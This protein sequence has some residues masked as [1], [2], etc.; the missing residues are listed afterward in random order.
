M[1]SESTCVEP[2]PGMTL[3]VFNSSRS[4]PSTTTTFLP[5]SSLLSVAMPRP[6]CCSPRTRTY[7]YTYRS[8]ESIELFPLTVPGPFC[9]PACRFEDIDSS[10]CETTA[11]TILLNGRQ[12]GRRSPK[13]VCRY[14][15]CHSTNH[16]SSRSS[17]ITTMAGTDGNR[18]SPK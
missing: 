5:F 15:Y 9:L 3:I 12:P 2:N 16:R 14:L 10:S 7:A 6:H 13:R 8:R 17:I 18:A 1:G 11:G 4:L